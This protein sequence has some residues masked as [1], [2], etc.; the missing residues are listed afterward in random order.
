M[1]AQIENLTEATLPVYGTLDLPMWFRQ[2]HASL[3]TI[4]VAQDQFSRI[5]QRIVL[6]RDLKA[7]VMNTIIPHEGPYPITTKGT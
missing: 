6:D 7:Y 5:T 3:A 2:I 1:G 4:L